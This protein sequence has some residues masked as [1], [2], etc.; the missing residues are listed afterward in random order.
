M[1]NSFFKISL[2]FILTISVNIQLFSQ[3]TEGVK[4]RIVEIKKWY[5]EIQSIGLINCKSKSYV[6]YEDPFNSNAKMPFD[7]TVS[8]CRLNNTYLIRKAQFH[9]YEWS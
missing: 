3:S 2:I 4:N 1:K 6:E 5:S 7:Q 9:G 8:V